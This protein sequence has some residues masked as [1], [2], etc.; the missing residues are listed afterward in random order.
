VFA[1]AA[2]YSAIALLT[3]VT[4]VIQ[5]GQDLDIGIVSDALAKLPGELKV[6]PP[7]DESRVNRRINL[8]VIGVD[9]RPGVTDEAANTDTI[10]VLT[11]DP[12]S[13]TMSGLS[14]PRDMLIQ[15][16]YPGGF[17]G[18]D[19]IN[20]AYAVG[21]RA[22]KSRD[23]AAAQ[24]IA[25]FKFNFNIDI[26]RWVY[27]DFRDVS[28]LIDT[29]GEIQVDIPEELAVYDWWYTDDDRTNP[30]YETFAP[31]I[32]KLNGYRAVA[33]GRY[34]NDS[35]FYRIKRQQLVLTAA[36]KA[37]FARGILDQNPAELWN[38]Y[39]DL[40]KHNIPL[41]EMA[42]YL[43]LLRD[44]GGSIS[45]YSVADPVNGVDTMISYTVPE[46]GAAVLQ[47]VPENVKFWIGQTFTKSR[48]AKSVV[49]IQ[50]AA[51]P[52]GVQKAETLALHF[53]LDRYLPTVLLGADVAIEP[54]TRIILHSP[55]RRPM[56]E[57]IAQ[58]IGMPGSVIEERTRT[59]KSEP[60]IIIVI[61][62]DHRGPLATSTPA[63]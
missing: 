40:V 59:S 41:S 42:S 26:D 46:S 61:G 14:F 9:N 15:I 21:Y 35:D 52:S 38:I 12:V 2:F 39:R 32:N 28:E 56:A 62:Q 53:K 43:P 44:T 29:V 18:E 55:N 16:H 34:R 5:K 3:R 23:A 20:T 50:N 33:F 7:S 36:I 58:W 4:P 22:T 47:W 49:E 6:Q 31:G 17:V 63:R 54:K 13:K 10:M 1:L 60:D 27:M 37:V 45:L 30:H 51:G 48:Y 57:D 25:D 24:L 8:L 19:R 11:M